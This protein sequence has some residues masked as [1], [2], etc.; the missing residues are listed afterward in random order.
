MH[1]NALILYEFIRQFLIDNGS[2]KKTEK[3]TVYFFLKDFNYI[4]FTSSEAKPE[5]LI[6][7]V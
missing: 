4:N 1:E 6:V 7:L 3:N 5:Y 2:R